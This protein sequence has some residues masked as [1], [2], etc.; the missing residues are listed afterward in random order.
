MNDIIIVGTGGLAREFTSW[1]SGHFSIIGYS[2]TNAKEHSVFALPGSYFNN[3][4]TPQS[5]G[6]DLAVIA[7]GN[8]FVKA[9]LFDILS[10]VGFRFPFFV[11]PSSVVAKSAHLNEGVIISPNCVISP[12]VTLNRLS[13]V[14]ICCSIAHDAAIGDFTQI[15]PGARIGG[16]SIIGERVLIGSGVTIL[17]GVNVGAG[18]IIGSGSVVFSKVAEGATIMGNP[19]KR[20]RAFEQLL[21]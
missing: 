20:M 1:C 3:D 21:D 11:H 7:I 4:V 12:N 5:V 8:P 2:S 19:G 6:T 16:F 15:N 18:A 10:K 9:K 17:Q 13:Y 14:N